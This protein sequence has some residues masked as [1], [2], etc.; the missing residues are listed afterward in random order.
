VVGFG[1]L[2]DSGFPGA[3]EQ[4]LGLVRCK[5][6]DFQALQSSG[7]VW[8][9]ARLWI[10]RRYRAVVGFGPLQDSGFP[11]AAEQWL[12]LVRCKTV[13]FQA[14][15]SSGWVWCAARQWIS[16]RCIAVVGFGSLQD[17]GFPGASEQWLGLVRCKTVDFQGLQSSDWVWSAAS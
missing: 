7:W 1:P 4:M 11:G 8:S 5:T 9:A 16:R 10:S 2:Q 17:G 12:G 15:Q 14:L 13:D 3:A 6:V